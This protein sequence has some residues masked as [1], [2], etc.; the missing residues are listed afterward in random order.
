MTDTTVTA[1]SSVTFSWNVTGASTLSISNIGVVTGTSQAT[2]VNATTDYVLTASNEFGST[3]SSTITVTVGTAPVIDT[4]APL[5]ASV[6]AGTNV[7]LL[8]ETSGVITTLTLDPGGID[9]TG[10]ASYDVIVNETTT[11]TLTASNDFG[12][13]IKQTE[14]TVAAGPVIIE[15]KADPPLIASGANSTLSWSVS[16]SGTP[17]I[18]IT[19]VSNV[20]QDLNSSVVVSPVSST[21]YEMTV[22]DAFGVASASVDVGVTFTLTVN[23]SLLGGVLASVSSS[24]VGLDCGVLL[25]SCEAVFV[26]GTVVTLSYGDLTGGFDGWS[27][28]DAL[29]GDD[30]VV[31]MDADK[32]VEASFSV[33]SVP[34]AAVDDAFVV[35]QG[36][37]LTVPVGSGVLGNDTDFSGNGLSAVLVN[38]VSHGS[39]VLASN[40]SFEYTPESTF[41]G[42]D[43]FTYYAFDGA[44]TSNTATVTLTVTPLAT[45]TVT[46]SAGGSVTSNPAGI[47]CPTTCSATYPPDESV[48]LTAV[49]DSGF[50][51]DSWGDAC[52]AETSN[53]CTLTLN[54][55]TNVQVSFEPADTPPTTSGL[56]DVTTQED[57]PDIQIT[58]SSAF[59]DNEDSSSDLSYAVTSVS[60]SSLFSSVL[61]VDDVLTLVLAGDANGV[62]DVSVSA[63]DSAAQ[64]VSSTFMVSVAP[65]ND[66]PVADAGANQTVDVNTLVTLDASAS[67]D[68]DEDT[69]VYTWA[70]SARPAGSSVVLSD[71]SGV[72]VSFTP[73]VAGEYVIGLSVTDG[74]LTATDEVSV[75]VIP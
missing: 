60:N 14:V 20:P 41:S 25:T 15:L 48:T 39:L 22:T 19:D 28:C 10:D 71:T 4:F 5:L 24:P 58:L 67:T 32:T 68:V 74:D 36:E 45:L 73:D 21:T 3:D 44:N 42:E 31:T 30:C 53:T 23:K 69:L 70:F 2:T 54:A 26:E 40:G 17:T 50:D 33:V 13:T 46:T 55:D 63:T 61:V 38:N 49:A 47:N 65:V 27:G 72:S 11:F 52:A 29:S 59:N 18:V 51:F 16:S 62:S 56:P 6:P 8:W 37:V 43:S 35:V 66:A 34:P 7:T 75:T 1:G 9:V 12:V 57:A 64:S